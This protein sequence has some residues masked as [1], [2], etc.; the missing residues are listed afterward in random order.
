MRSVGKLFSEKLAHVK[1]N[2]PNCI[3]WGIEDIIL[4]L[5]TCKTLAD[6]LAHN[7]HLAHLRL[8][9]NDISPMELAAIV[10]GIILN[11]HISYFTLDCNTALGL[12]G[13]FHL[14]YMVKHNTSIK[15]MIVHNCGLGSLMTEALYE[16]LARNVRRRDAC[17]KAQV[18]LMGIWARRRETILST[19]PR[20][21]MRLICRTLWIAYCHHEAWNA[22]TNESGHGFNTMQYLRGL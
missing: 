21:I 16:M 3:V 15:H 6:A 13:L 19:Q 17:R 5:D 18:T 7:T 11:K 22:S 9:N 10:P 2:D 4:R 1:S 12:A 20:E 8:V 14:E